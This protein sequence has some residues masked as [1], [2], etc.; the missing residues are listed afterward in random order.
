[1]SNVCIVE[2]FDIPATRYRNSSGDATAD[3]RTSVDI[4]LLD[5]SAYTKTK[6]TPQQQKE[7]KDHVYHTHNRQD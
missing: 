3:A 7:E 5:R 6:Q 2:F 4:V 1:M